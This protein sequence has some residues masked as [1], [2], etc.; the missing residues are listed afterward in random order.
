MSDTGCNDIT[1]VD[2]SS[3]F[4]VNQSIAK[5]KLKQEIFHKTIIALYESINIRHG[6]QMCLGFTHKEILT[7]IMYKLA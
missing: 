1:V 6:G 2:C 5:W 7:F 3:E 4:N